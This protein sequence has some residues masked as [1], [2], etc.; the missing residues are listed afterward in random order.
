M[1][2]VSPRPTEFL[3]T[4]EY[5]R[6]A[7]F[8]DACR[9]YRYIGLCYGLPGVGKALSARHYADWD[10]LEPF[11]AARPHLMTPPIVPEAA[12][13][14]SVCYTPS[15]TTT[16]KQIADELNE[17]C[18]QFSW[19]VEEAIH[20]DE[21]RMGQTLHNWI[22]LVLVDEADR[23]KMPTLE[24][25]R[26]FYDRRQVGLVLIGMPGLEKRLARYA[27][28]YSRVGFVHHF[29]TLGDD[30]LR[31]ILQHHWQ[32]LGLTLSP[33][34]FT[35]AEAIA[36]VTRITGGNFRLVQRLFMQVE[37]ILQIN[38]VH[39]ITKEVVEAARENLVI[40]PT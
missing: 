15:I 36:A 10:R 13:C 6:F 37:R 35:D 20:P 5:R 21:D 2:D 14:R 32:Q 33:T 40:G 7:E 23:L 22:E 24:Q 27:Q 26:D 30:E 4:K 12:T 39:T 11:I 1:T 18:L 38:E 29:R 8:C 31:F 25:L 19:T 17:I 9:R 28:F 16:P 3:V 34:D